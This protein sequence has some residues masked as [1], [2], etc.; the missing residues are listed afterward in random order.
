[1]QRYYGLKLPGC[2]DASYTSFGGTPAPNGGCGWNNSIQYYGDDQDTHYN[3][4]RAEVVKQMA[5]GYS[6]N[7]S[8]AWQ[9][10]ISQATGY[11]TWSRV[12]VR[13]RDSALRQQQIIVYGVLQLPF[14]HGKQFLGHTNKFV[15]QLV[16]GY[17]I[18][19]VVNYS[20]GLPF[21]LS[22]NACTSANVG[23]APCYVNGDAH[24]FQKR[25][26][27]TP[28]GNLLWYPAYTS[29]GG[30]SRGAGATLSSAGNGTFSTPV[31]DQIGTVGRNTA[32]GPNFFNT[33]LSL[34][35][36]FAI[37]ESISFILR[38]D[39]Y[40]AF[41]HIN[42]GTPNGNLQSGGA[43]TSGPLPQGSTGATRQLQFSGRV[44][45]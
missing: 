17:E 6:L 13:G 15:N 36:S 37:H 5:H 31:V 32:F 11:S 41:N 43:I 14:G 8:Y 7:V 39:G 33:D 45:F 24:S 9:Q 10:A 40:N 25:V 16:S 34:Q 29:S 44:Q 30:D 20:S 27:G 38:A 2:S 42:W 22:Y 18:N 3:S 26:S 23:S 35:K 4:M 12:A 1:M 28:N 21:T 19:P